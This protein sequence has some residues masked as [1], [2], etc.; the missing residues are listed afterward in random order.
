MAKKPVRRSPTS[1]FRPKPEV[2]IDIGEMPTGLPDVGKPVSLTV[3]GT[4]TK[5][6]KDEYSTL[7]SMTVRTPKVQV[8]KGK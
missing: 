7:D 8:Q 2:R 5:V 1:A 6:A 3:R 4:L